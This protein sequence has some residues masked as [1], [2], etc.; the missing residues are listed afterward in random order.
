MGNYSYL[1]QFP[2]HISSTLL[3]VNILLKY[4]KHFAKVLISA[5]FKNYY[6]M[7]TL[8]FFQAIYYIILCPNLKHCF[9]LKIWC[10]LTHKVMTASGIIFMYMI[11]M[12]NI[13]MLLFYKT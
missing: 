13:H 12:F 7:Q 8:Y 1:P 10:N 6:S 4:K 11:I 9:E 5:L 2:I 3:P